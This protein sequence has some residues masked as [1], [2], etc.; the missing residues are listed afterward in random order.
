VHVESDD[1]VEVQHYENAPQRNGQSSIWK[2]FAIGLGTAIISLT[3]FVLHNAFDRLDAMEAAVT[4]NTVAVAE[5]SLHRLEHETQ[6][7]FWIAVIEQLREKVHELNTNSQARP[8]PFTGSDGRELR[9]QIAELRKIIGQIE[10]RV[11]A[12]EQC[13]K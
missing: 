12:T 4:G 5:N 11:D 10:R 6:S 2:T 9:N 3:T 13:C 8:D 7:Q 1:N